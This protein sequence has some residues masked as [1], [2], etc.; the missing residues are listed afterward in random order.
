MAVTPVLVATKYARER[1]WLSNDAE[2]RRGCTRPEREQ[3]L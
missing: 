1:V 3:R 2:R